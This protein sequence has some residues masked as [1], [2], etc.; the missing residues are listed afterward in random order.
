MPVRVVT[1]STAYLPRPVLDELGIDVVSLY[2]TFAEGD[3]VPEVDIAP[4]EFYARLA[5]GR[6]LPRSSQP[7]TAEFDRVFRAALDAGQDV[8]GVFLSAEMSGT[9]AGAGLARDAITAERPDAVIELVDSRSNCMQLGF[10][11]LAAARAARDGASASEAAEAARAVIPRSRFLF[12]PATLEYLRRGGRIG[13]ASA[14]LGAILQVKPILTVADGV[15]TTVAKVR[16]TKRAVEEI[17]T[18]AEA[19]IARHGL[20]EIAVHHI[21]AEETAREVAASFREALGR[22]VPVVA[23]GAVIGTHVG[24]G[25]IGVVYVTREAL[26]PIGAS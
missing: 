19:D 25:T 2:V 18:L 10:S 5:A 13:N 22:E 14:L 1:D 8:V 26:G 9:F 17:V 3:S 4:A 6:S 21:D 7:S 16:T 24:P 23:I 15:T 20:A 12:A 11:V